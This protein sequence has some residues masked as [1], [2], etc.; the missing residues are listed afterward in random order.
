V[1]G[2][3]RV[4]GKAI[5]P[6]KATLDGPGRSDCVLPAPALT[7]GAIGLDPTADEILSRIAEDAKTTHGPGW[8]VAPRPTPALAAGALEGNQTPRL[9]GKHIADFR[10][11][12]GRQ[13]GNSA[14]MSEV[15]SA[16]HQAQ[17][18]EDAGMWQPAWS[19]NRSYNAT[20]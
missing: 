6:V 3:A 1:R 10:H 5:W 9:S 13:G 11:G 17:R 18:V 4:T 14:G 12:E 16:T 15:A 2:S 7:A 19:Y 8:R 20:P